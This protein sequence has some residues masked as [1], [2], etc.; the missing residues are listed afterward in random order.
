MAGRYDDWIGRTETHVE[1]LIPGPMRGLAATIEDREL[2]PATGDAL[3]ELWHWLYFLPVVRQSRIAGD[4]HPVRGGFLPPITLERRMWAGGRLEFHDP[5][6]IGDT[7]TKAS[8]IINV[9]EKNGAAGPMA[10]VTVRHE[11][12]TERGLAISEE[13]DIVYIAM[14]KEFR[15]PKPVPAP[16][17]ITWSEPFEVDTVVLFRFSALTFNGHRIH[18]DLPYA[19]DVE[20]YPGLVVHGPLQAMLLMGAARRRQP[21]RRPAAFRFRGVRPLFDFEDLR[22]VGAPGEDG[23]RLVTVNGDGHV[24]M[25]AGITWR[26]G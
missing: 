3:P 7:V 17:T 13:Q 18:I 16:E 9:A 11:L 10:F 5:L 2:E 24:C 8:E 21:D 23:D 12:T 22:L 14:P 1:T 4:G 25:Q 26:A 6:R 19:R 15:P 20:K